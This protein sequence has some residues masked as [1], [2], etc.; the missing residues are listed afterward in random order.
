MSYVITGSAK[1]KFSLRKRYYSGDFGQPSG[2]TTSPPYCGGITPLQ[3]MLYDLGY[4]QDTVDG[5]WGPN[6]Q[7]AVISFAG[8]NGLNVGGGI[9]SGFCQTLID[10]WNSAQT[11]SEPQPLP[12]TT[13]PLLH[14]SAI[15][16]L[17]LK[18]PS[19]S[20]P[21]GQKS[22]PVTRQGNAEP[23]AGAIGWWGSLSQTEKIAVVAGGTLAVG[24][25][26]YVIV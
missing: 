18:K 5:F 8:D 1:P 26:L 11:Q 24:A 6:T 20:I 25:V 9:T 22:S 23:S 7:K 14:S 2:A 15:K 12:T 16:N 21:S 13:S 17:A 3:Q 10:K 4:Y 19:S